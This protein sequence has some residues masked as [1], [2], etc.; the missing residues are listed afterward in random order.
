MEIESY[1]IDI[2]ARWLDWFR[3]QSS[4]SGTS[5]LLGANW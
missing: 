5:N 3:L 4:D 1:T 2:L